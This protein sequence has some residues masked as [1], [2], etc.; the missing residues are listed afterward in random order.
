M[1]VVQMLLVQMKLLAH[2]K[3]S[4]EENCSCCNFARIQKKKEMLVARMSQKLRA[5]LKTSREER[6]C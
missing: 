1:L 3:T 6:S 4:R 2:L 5:H